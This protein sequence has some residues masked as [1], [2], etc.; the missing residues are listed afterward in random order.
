M[1]YIA[2]SN[3]YIKQVSFGAMIECGGTSCVEYKGSVPSGYDSLTSWFLA[4]CE[5]LYRWKIV[6]GELTYD[7]NA[8]PP[9]DVPP[10]APSGYGLG[11][12]EPTQITDLNTATKSGWYKF[13][14][15]AANA[16]DTGAYW[17]YVAAYSPAFIYQE[18]YNDTYKV[19]L[20]RW[21]RGDGWSPWEWVDPPMHLS[22]EYRTTERFYAKSVYK[23]VLDVGYLG[24][25]VN[26]FNHGIAN[27]DE[28]VGIEMI[29]EGFGLFTAHCDAEF[30]QTGIYL[31][32]PWAAGAV[33][34]ILAY[35]KN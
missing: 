27:I 21:L 3:G 35:T 18:V 4:E 29:N 9:V 14:S 10:Y 23:Y 34:L 33:K 12:V 25:G 30:S 24:A 16:P 15:Y 32:M 17:L 26:S 20:S 8:T 28:C 22:T 2:D 1:R 7:G 19:I 31:N 6:G 11:A 13:G 5:N